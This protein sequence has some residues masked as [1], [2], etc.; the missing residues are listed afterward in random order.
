MQR[1]EATGGK[2]ITLPAFN[3]KS[4][5]TSN[6]SSS[7]SIC[8]STG[9]ACARASN[10]TEEKKEEPETKKKKIPYVVFMGVGCTSKSYTINVFTANAASVDPDPVGN[11][12][13]IGQITRLGMGPA[14]D[15]TI[16]NKSSRKCRVPEA[17]RVLSAAGFE[18]RLG[19]STDE[20]GEAKEKEKVKIVVTDLETG[21]VVGKEVYGE[22]PGFEPRIVWL[23]T[24]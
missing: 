22:L 17:S 24:Y 21:E 1:F 18:D 12:D 8:N 13:F 9:G 5:A 10:T 19:G 15:V 11:P 7:S 20:D 6:S 3:L 16:K 4:P 2:A 14:G 23:A